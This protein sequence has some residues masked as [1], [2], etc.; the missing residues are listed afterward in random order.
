MM[1]ASDRWNYGLGIGSTFE[2][3]ER[4]RIEQDRR[5]FKLRELKSELEN[6]D[7]QQLAEDP[8]KDDIHE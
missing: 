4:L 5:E 7:Q 8:E 2:E 6:E 3:E 1:K